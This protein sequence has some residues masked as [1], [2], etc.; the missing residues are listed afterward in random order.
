M[1]YD[2]TGAN[3]GAIVTVG[4]YSTLQGGTVMEMGT[5]AEMRAHV[6]TKAAEDHDFRSRLMEDPNAAISSEIGVDIPDDYNIVV[7]EDSGTTTHLVLPPSGSLT[8][9]ELEK[10]AGGMIIVW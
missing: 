10:A 6:M 9:Q 5:V 7:H 8:D 4:H 3:M 1:E 2:L